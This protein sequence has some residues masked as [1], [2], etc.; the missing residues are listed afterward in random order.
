MPSATLKD[1]AKDVKTY[2]GLAVSLFGVLNNYLHVFM[3]LA[4]SL[5]LQTNVILIVVGSIAVGITI[6]R[7]YANR[8][9]GL[10]SWAARVAGVWAG[11]G[12]LAWAVYMPLVDFL[13]NHSHSQSA[14]QWF[15]AVQVGA[16][17]FPFLCWSVAV[18][19]LLALFL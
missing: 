11:V 2:V 6:A 7:I 9:P 12:F 15:D 8:G 10:N 5:R 13:A 16:Y 18:A 3:P 1:I 14:S 17:V 19:A 4:P